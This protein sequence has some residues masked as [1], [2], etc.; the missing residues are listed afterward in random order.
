MHGVELFDK[1]NIAKSGVQS[2]GFA[3]SPGA[4]LL[5]LGQA[6]TRRGTPHMS[7]RS[8]SVSVGTRGSRRSRRR[9]FTITA[10]AIGSAG[11]VL[12]APAGALL[13]PAEAQAQITL[14]GIGT[15]TNI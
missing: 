12:A 7:N 15:F 8:K 10:A 4:K 13:T 1:Q 5:L 14:P 3:R 11:I 9:P 2:S 6:T